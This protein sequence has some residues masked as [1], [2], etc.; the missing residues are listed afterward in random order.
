MS[1]CARSHEC[2]DARRLEGPS[3]GVVAG[4][5]YGRWHR[6]HARQH[7]PGDERGADDARPAGERPTSVGR[8]RGG[9]IARAQAHSRWR[10]T[11]CPESQVCQRSPCAEHVRWR[12]T[13]RLRGTRS[14]GRFPVRT[15][16]ASPRVLH[17]KPHG[18]RTRD[19]AS[20]LA[21]MHPH[22]RNENGRLREGP[23]VGGEGLS[24]GGAGRGGRGGRGW[25]ARH[26]CRC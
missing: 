20:A 6:T 15:Q 16:V 5:Q 18:V 4:F 3:F 13:R 26:R 11:S 17:P 12:G 21:T 7:S 8:R 2:R 24:D 10:V 22:T 9:A 25:R 19:D 14:V 1:A 23:A